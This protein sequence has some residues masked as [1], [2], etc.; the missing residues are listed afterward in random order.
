MILAQWKLF[1]DL[2]ECN[3]FLRR[4]HEAGHVKE[5]CDWNSLVMLG[6]NVISYLAVVEI[7]CM[8]TLNYLFIDNVL[9]APFFWLDFPAGRRTHKT[10]TGKHDKLIAWQQIYLLLASCNHVK[11]ILMRKHIHPATP[12]ILHN[13]MLESSCLFPPLILLSSA[14]APWW[15][16]TRHWL[17]DYL[18]PQ[19][20]F[21]EV[22]AHL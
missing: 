13:H 7:S 1:T 6:R 9:Y 2:L 22:Q 18:R 16:H 10:K 3:L 17:L 4:H 14:F 20:P 21:L 8:Q 5:F 19:R 11:V 15:E 12:C